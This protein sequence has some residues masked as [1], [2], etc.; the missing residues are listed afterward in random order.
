[1]KMNS[2]EMKV[3]R[4]EILRFVG[5]SA[6]GLI[7]SPLPWKALNDTA[8]WSQNWPGVPE[9]ERGEVTYK[10]TSCS[11]CP[12]AC[13]MRVRCIGNRPVSISG[14]AAHP[15]NQGALCPTGIVAHHLRYHPARISRPVRIVSKNG[16]PQQTIMTIDE[17][18]N[19]I[20]GAMKGAATSS[21]AIAFVDGR[22]GRTTSYLFQQFAANIPNGQYISAADTSIGYDLDH[23]RTILSFGAPLFDGWGTPSR[24]ARYLDNKPGKKQRVIQVETCQ[25]RTGSMSDLW[26]PIKPATEAAFAL[27]L[28]NVILQERFVLTKSKEIKEIETVAGPFTPS[29]VAE[30][31]GVTAEM[32]KDVA[33]Q[34]IAVSPSVAIADND[35]ISRESQAAIMSLNILVGNIGQTGGVTTKRDIA[36]PDEVQKK[37]ISTVSD[38]YSIPDYSVRVM[39]LDE[40]L[41]ACKLPDTLLQK[42][43][44]P[45]KGI[46]VS[47]SPFVTERSFAMQYV[48][49]TPVFLETLS[50][51]TSGIDSAVTTLGLSTPLTA[52]PSGV[53]DPIQFTQELARKSGVSNVDAGTTE[54]IIKKRLEVIYKNKRGSVYQGSIGQSIDVKSFASSDDVWKV[55]ASGGCWMDSREGSKVQPVIHLNEA[56]SKIDINNLKNQNEN[57]LILV[58]VAVESV[59]G[60]TQ[61]SPLLSKVGQESGLRPC[62]D[63][64]YL[65]PLTA[66]RLGIIDYERVVIH[67]QKGSMEV[68]SRFD[69]SVMPGIIA[70]ASDTLQK[71]ILAFCEMNDDASIRP[72]PVQIEKV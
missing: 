15:L 21:Q 7:L 44:I 41:S 12:A 58:S 3:T 59:Y 14:L 39:F 51:V 1:M 2:M 46:I 33:R 38:I 16:S 17:V 62:G 4:R 60:S 66:T 40:S 43:L 34:F 71:N 57:S 35:V 26:I 8:N 10:F 48:I 9:P 64:V 56:L 61:V 69:A 13:G 63:Q 24:T 67:T 5:G 49:P 47:L 20:S 50:E 54:E 6:V 36:S 72:T 30:I 31:C 42:K 45:E 11:L 28:A 22:P 27:G 23:A 55:L 65:H 68:Q 37:T 19:E 18:L 70:A 32:I 29:A 25:S 52:V 53:L